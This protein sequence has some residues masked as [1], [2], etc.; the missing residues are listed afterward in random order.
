ME[1]S[2][3]PEGAGGGG[4]A[5]AKAEG[6]T[7]A[8]ITRLQLPLPRTVAARLGDPEGHRLAAPS[9]GALPNWAAWH[10]PA[11]GIVFPACSRQA[12]A[13]KIPPGPGAEDRLQPVRLYKESQP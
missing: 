9:P 10:S 11:E 13:N 2:A 12:S 7:A 6:L 8:P 3:T 5:F 4:G 1:G